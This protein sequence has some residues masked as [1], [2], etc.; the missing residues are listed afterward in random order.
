MYEHLLVDVVWKICA[1]LVPLSKVCAHED[2]EGVSHI[3]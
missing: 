2:V 3:P 1:E